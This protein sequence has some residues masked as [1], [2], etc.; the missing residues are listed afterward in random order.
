MA[1]AVSAFFAGT[2]ALRALRARPLAAPAGDGAADAAPEG[3]A[4]LCEAVSAPAAVVED[5][6]LTQAN[7]AFLALLDFG[8]RRAELVGQPVGRLVH[9]L[10]QGRLASLL[11]AVAQGERGGPPETLR[12]L[13]SDGDSIR[14]QVCAAPLGAVVGAVLLQLGPDAPAGGP[15]RAR[16]TEISSAMLAQLDLVV[17]SV[18]AAGEM[19]YVN[20]AWERLAGDPQVDVRGRQFRAYLHP[21]DRD[22]VRA[23]FATILH[24]RQQQAMREVR[25]IGAGGSVHWMDLRAHPCVLADGEVI[26]VLATLIE[27]TPRK[28]NEGGASA[29]RRLPQTLLANLPG[30]VYRSRNDEEW[31]M[32]FV[33]DGSLELT[34]FEPYELVKNARTSWGRLIHPDDR[35][36]VRQQVQI[37]VAQHRPFRMTYRIVD[38]QGRESWVWEQGQGVFSSSGELL[39]L[40]GFITDVK[41]RIGA[42]EQTLRRQDVRLEAAPADRARFEQRV[43]FLLQHSAAAGY[44][45]ALLWV[46]ID[47]FEAACARI[48]PRGADQALAILADRLDVLQGP[49]TA[50]SWLGSGQFAMAVTDFRLGGARR[51]VPE[52]TEIMPA[53][54]E[55]AG[56]LGRAIG[57]PFV[58][59]GGQ[60]SLTA[61]IGI[62]TS[63]AGYDGC[64]AMIAAARNAAREARERMG[65][66]H[67]EFADE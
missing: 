49:G 26:G 55:I 19:T 23:E 39:A 29:A 50:V 35:E 5:A 58:L 15:G 66:G 16:S 40:E 34:G 27:I 67:C 32:D 17:V 20:R 7:R 31:T 61:S 22:A 65:P 44:A 38:A 24:G 57:S 42:E 6:V 41:M 46:D 36:F 48:G 45:C 14:M 60:W 8:G 37:S 62:A 2:L 54:S 3:A 9:P 25:L 59:E 1:L 64:A 21:A 28:R 51:A 53:C 56:R 4:E 30:M 33:S 43:D 47:D 13:R 10:D 52:V 18:D 12:L 11:A 63:Q